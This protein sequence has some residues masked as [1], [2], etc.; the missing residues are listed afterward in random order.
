MN[1]MLV[2][3]VLKHY[4]EHLNMIYY[5]LSNNSQEKEKM[6]KCFSKK[7]LLKTLKP[8]IEKTNYF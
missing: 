6:P 8:I 3:E 7:L 5:Y 4:E 2:L 1:K